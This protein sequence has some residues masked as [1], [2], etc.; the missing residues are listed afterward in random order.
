MPLIFYYVHGTDNPL[1][2]AVQLVRQSLLLPLDIPE[3][4]SYCCQVDF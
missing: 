1:D 3:D 4:H 2:K